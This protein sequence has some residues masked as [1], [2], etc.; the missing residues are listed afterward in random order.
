MK[1]SAI[2]SI[3]IISACSTLMFA[4]VESGLENVHGK[5]LEVVLEEIRAHQGIGKDEKIDPEKVSDDQLEELG[6][7][8]M[9][10]MHPDPRE[11][12][13]MD[14]M[15]GGEGSATLSAMHR[16][17][18]YNYLR[19]YYGGMMGSGMMGPGMMGQGMMSGPSAYD[20]WQR[21][22]SMM[23]TGYGNVFFW[24]IFLILITV[25]IYLV[26]QTRTKRITAPSKETPLDILARR[27]AKGEITKDDFERM[28]KDII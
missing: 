8:L 5:P 3:I 24:I 23:N 26:V 27:Y 28:K 22:H 19:G 2:I 21:G 12:E 1:K 14:N 15:M 18:G 17:M 10:V 11:H 25:I 13:W 16:I 9:S 6:D 4:H 20:P 7:A